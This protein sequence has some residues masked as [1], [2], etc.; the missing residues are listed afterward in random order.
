MVVCPSRSHCCKSSPPKTLPHQRPRPV[1]PIWTPR[2][3]PLPL[4]LGGPPAPGISQSGVTYA[5]VSVTGEA[6]LHFI[7]RPA[8]DHLGG[9]H[10]LCT[11]RETSGMST[12]ALL[13]GHVLGVDLVGRTAPPR[14]NVWRSF[15]TEAP[16]LPGPLQRWWLCPSDGCRVRG[17]RWRLGVAFP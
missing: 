4:S 5:V 13:G 14:L 9:T 6:T 3:A 16:V 15:W 12:C 1:S 8:A 7:H 11:A 17:V 2:P 10:F